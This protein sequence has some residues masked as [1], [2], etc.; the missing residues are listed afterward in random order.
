MPMTAPPGLHHRS[1]E[2]GTLAE[3][4]PG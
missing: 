4:R 2:V 1:F 3:V